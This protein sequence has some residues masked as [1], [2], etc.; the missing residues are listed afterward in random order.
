MYLKNVYCMNKRTL[1]ICYEY[2]IDLFLSHRIL[3]MRL[4]KV[5]NNNINKQQKLYSLPERPYIFDFGRNV[6]SCGCISFRKCAEIVLLVD[7]K[8]LWDI[9]P[10]ATF[11]MLRD[12]REFLS[13]RGIGINALGIYCAF[14]NMGA[15]L[16][17]IAWLYKY[18]ACAV[19]TPRVN[20][21]HVDILM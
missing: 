14:K 19:A 6:T 2:T 17:I 20:S 7:I 1:C 15:E 18:F 11:F 5:A 21:Q 12:R 10:F 3:Y 9:S 8:F 4:V 16:Y 13:L